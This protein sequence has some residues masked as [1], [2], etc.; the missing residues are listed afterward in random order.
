MRRWSA[1]TTTT[2][3]ES[4]QTQVGTRTPAMTFAGT[5]VTRVA[6]NTGPPWAAWTNVSPPLRRRAVRRAASGTP[7]TRRAE[8]MGGPEPVPPPGG[9]PDLY[10]PTFSGDP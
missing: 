1:F 9:F 8:A 10:L 4:R 3:I 6:G 2:C 7:P 5:T